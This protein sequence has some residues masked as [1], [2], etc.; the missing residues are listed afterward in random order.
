[1]QK[2]RYI[3]YAYVD[4]MYKNILLYNILIKLIDRVPLQKCSARDLDK[5]LKKKINRH[6]ILCKKN[7]FLC[8]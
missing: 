4:Y 1:M 7:D 2:W 5:T 3:I 8:I 6:T